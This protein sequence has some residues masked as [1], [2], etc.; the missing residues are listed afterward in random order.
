MFL[1]GATREILWDRPRNFE[2]WSDDEDENPS[3]IFSHISGKKFQARFNYEQTHKHEGHGCNRVLN[4]E[5]S[6]PGAET[7]EP[8]SY[9][10]G[11]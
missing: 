10:S 8:G 6:S 11:N 3:Q 2:P 9:G 5:A 4:L 1:F 7:L